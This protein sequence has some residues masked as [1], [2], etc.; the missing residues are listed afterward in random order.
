MGRRDPRELPVPAISP[1][2]DEDWPTQAASAIVELVET[3]RDRTTGKVLFAARVAVWGV[4]LLPVLTMLLVLGAIATIRG[5]DNAV[6]ESVW[7]VY[8]G[9]GTVFFLVGCVLMRKAGTP[10]PPEP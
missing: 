6:T 2:K 4:L 10:P 9:I 3:V 8:V 5:L 1:A 7:A